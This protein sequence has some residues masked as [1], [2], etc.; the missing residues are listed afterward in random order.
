[1]FS[2]TETNISQISHLS[3]IDSREKKNKPLSL[4]FVFSSSEESHIDS[5]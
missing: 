2:L 3:N 1:M 4:K 5:N